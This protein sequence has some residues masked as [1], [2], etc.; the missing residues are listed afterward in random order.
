MAEIADSEPLM[1]QL[2]KYL[3]KLVAQ[4]ADPT[5]MTEEEFFAKVDKSLEQARQ[6]RVHRIESK[7]ELSQFL[8]S[9]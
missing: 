4:K 2:A 9:L 7:E 6:G 3:K 5:L 1:R 8:N